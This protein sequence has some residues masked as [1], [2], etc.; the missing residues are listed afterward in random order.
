MFRHGVKAYIDKAEDKAVLRQKL[1][2]VSVGEIIIPDDVAEVLFSASEFRHGFQSISD[3][4]DI[5]NYLSN[6]MNVKEIANILDQS[7]S[8]IEKK[9]QAIRKCFHVKTNS[10]LVYKALIRQTP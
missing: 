3:Y 5:I 2:M 4:K 10:E 7:E 1:L 9:L 8:A 6:G